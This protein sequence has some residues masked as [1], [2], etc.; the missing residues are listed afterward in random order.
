MVTEWPRPAGTVLVP[1]SALADPTLADGLSGLGLEVTVVTAYDTTTVDW[2]PDIRERVRGGEFG[3][4][5]LTSPSVARGVTAQG[6]PLPAGTVVACIGKSTA[7]GARAAG[8]PVHLV[9]DGS[10]AEG[11]V[12]A[13]GNHRSSAQHKQTR[14]EALP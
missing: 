5:L 13:L 8:L 11:L 7:A 2:D 4:V 14:T 1:Q 3:A 9:A 10:T 12:A 6:I